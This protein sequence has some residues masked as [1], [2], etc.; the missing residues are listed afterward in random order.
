MALKGLEGCRFL[1]WM[2]GV[3]FW[4]VCQKVSK[5]V[6]LVGYFTTRDPISIATNY[7]LK[8]YPASSALRV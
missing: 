4:D 6:G 3:E 5:M 7:F 2:T 1:A 8:G